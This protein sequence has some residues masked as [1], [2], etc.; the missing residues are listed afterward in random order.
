MTFWD[1]FIR[2]FAEMLAALALVGGGLV[3]IAI[4]CVA[5]VLLDKLRGKK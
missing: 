4:V 3:V 5:A 2:P 1:W